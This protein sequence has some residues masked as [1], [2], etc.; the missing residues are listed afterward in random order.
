MP[1]QNPFVG[2]ERARIWGFTFFILIDVVG[3]GIVGV[4]ARQAIFRNSRESCPIAG[5]RLGSY[6]IRMIYNFLL[7]NY[8]FGLRNMVLIKL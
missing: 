4:L 2:K 3:C 5:S 6:R 7:Y 8:S 1:D